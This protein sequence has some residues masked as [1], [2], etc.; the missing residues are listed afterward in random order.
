MSLK[1]IGA[2]TEEREKAGKGYGVAVIELCVCGEEAIVYHM[3]GSDCVLLI[4]VV[5]AT[6]AASVAVT[7][8]LAA[9]IYIFA[10]LLIIASVV[11]VVVVV[12][13]TVAVVGGICLSQTMT[14]MLQK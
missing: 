4:G 9:V 13:D 5:A 12:V 7:A 3:C 14:P 2:A 11:V 10:L 8:V 6:V 1:R